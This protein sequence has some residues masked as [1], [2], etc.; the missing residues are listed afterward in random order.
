MAYTAKTPGKKGTITDALN[1]KNIGIDNKTFQLIDER[2]PMVQKMELTVGERVEYR[3]ASQGDLTVKGKINF[4]GRDKDAPA[5]PS[6]PAPIQ[7][8]VPPVSTPPAEPKREPRII[9][10]Q[11]L[12]KTGSSVTLK[13]SKGNAEAWPADLDLIVFLNKP[14]GK[15]KVG[16]MV[17]VQ[18]IDNH[19][20]WIAKLMGAFDPSIPEKPFKTAQEILKENLDDKKAEQEKADAAPAQIN[21]EEAAKPVET[22]TE[23]E[24]ADLI[25]RGEAAKM[26]KIRKEAEAHAEQM[27]KEN[28][29]RKA[30]EAPK[31]PTMTQTTKEPAKVEQS[32]T[33]AL[34]EALAPAP[35][36]PEDTVF[37][38]LELTVQIDKF[39][40]AHVKVSGNGIKKVQSDF[41]TVLEAHLKYCNEVSK[42]YPRFD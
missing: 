36:D 37:V 27:K 34:P 39:R 7:P 22:I 35:I 23:T 24:A 41:K 32:A 21:K 10:G 5:A 33:V 11:Y 1:M 18:L 38:E 40:P 2:I 31:T 9:Q 17:K 3:I 4:I 29:A 15:V 14:D 12:S 13:D 8:F 30:V 26:E 16:D 6:Q 28:D 19:G 20:E 42:R 25:A